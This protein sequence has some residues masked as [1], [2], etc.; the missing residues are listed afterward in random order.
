[1]N[2]AES[3]KAVASNLD[4]KSLKVFFK[5]QAGNARILK[6]PK[7]KGY[8][9][10]IFADGS[11]IDVFKKAGQFSFD[12]LTDK[13]TVLANCWLAESKSI[14]DDITEIFR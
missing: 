3:I 7:L 2:I 10:I 4:E 1:M 13:E 5:S 11:A 8:K 12:L 6:S 14:I 9:V